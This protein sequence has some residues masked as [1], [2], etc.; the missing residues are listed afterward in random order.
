M[1]PRTTTA[2]VLSPG[3]ARRGMRSTHSVVHMIRTSPARTGHVSQVMLRQLSV[4]GPRPTRTQAGLF[5]VCFFPMSKPVSRSTDSSLSRLTS[6]SSYEHSARLGARG[7]IETVL[8]VLATQGFPR[9]K[10][11]VVQ[12]QLPKQR[13]FDIHTI[14]DESLDC[15]G[16]I[17]TASSCP[18]N[19]ICKKKVGKGVEGTDG[20]QSGFLMAERLLSS[21]QR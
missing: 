16:D 11:A 1:S 8:G 12:V 6:C 17:T 15:G 5:Q 21:V 19:Q 2:T 18:A 7:D 14:T 3:S 9:S 4:A 20:S 13:S 10:P